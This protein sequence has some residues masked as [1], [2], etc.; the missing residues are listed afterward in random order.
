M[1]QVL[2]LEFV[3]LENP[4]EGSTFCSFFEEM[5]QKSQN[6]QILWK[7]QKLIYPFPR[8]SLIARLRI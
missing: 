2:N 8:K 3:F 7:Q 5:L 6:N 4:F 1:P